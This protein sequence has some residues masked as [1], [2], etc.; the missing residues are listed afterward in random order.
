VPCLALAHCS[1]LATRAAS[2]AAGSTAVAAVCSAFNLLHEVIIGVG[3]VCNHFGQGQVGGHKVS[4][5]VSSL[6]NGI[7]RLS[8]HPSRSSIVTGVGCLLL[9]A[10]SPLF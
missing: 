8:N 7:G 6:D 10:G 5:V 4:Q 1:L 9:P 2:T 3:E